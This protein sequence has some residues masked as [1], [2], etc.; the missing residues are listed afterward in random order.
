MNDLTDD[1]RLAL[2]Y[3]IGYGI[4]EEGGA[5]EGDPIVSA[6][7]KLGLHPKGWQGQPMLPE[8]AA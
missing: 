1:E 2:E 7:R 8:E 4:T 5:E 3:L 6:C